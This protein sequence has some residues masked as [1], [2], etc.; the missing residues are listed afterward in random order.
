MLYLEIIFTNIY[1][2]LVYMLLHNTYQHHTAYCCFNIKNISK[3]PPPR[4]ILIISKLG[5]SCN[6]GEKNLVH[7]FQLAY[8]YKTNTNAK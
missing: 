2:S 5:K 7:K 8:F 4:K 3:A 1:K 6:T